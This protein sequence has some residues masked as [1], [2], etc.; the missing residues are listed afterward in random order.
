MTKAI[1]KQQDLDKVTEVIQQYFEGLHQGDIKKL[2][3]IFH[4]DAVLKKSWGEAH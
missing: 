3:V 4:A 2:D 1:S